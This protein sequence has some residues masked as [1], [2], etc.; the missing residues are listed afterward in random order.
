MD[1]LLRQRDLAA[2]LKRLEKRGPDE[3]YRGRTAELIAADNAFPRA[4]CAKL[5]SVMKDFEMKNR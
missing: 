5:V 2:T 3:F 4:G 1:D